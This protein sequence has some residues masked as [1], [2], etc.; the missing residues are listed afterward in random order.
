MIAKHQ[1]G[2]L[3]AKHQQGSPEVMSW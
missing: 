1:H 2:P 3:I